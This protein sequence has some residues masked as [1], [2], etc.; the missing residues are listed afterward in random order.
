MMQTLYGS[1]LV[2]IESDWKYEVGRWHTMAE[3]TSLLNSEGFPATTATAAMCPKRAY[4]RN[5]A[6][7]IQE[8]TSAD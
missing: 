6:N 8:P 7:N 2:G 3:S 1:R 5:N 4:A